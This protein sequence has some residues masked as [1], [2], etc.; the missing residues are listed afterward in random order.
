MLLPTE[1][2]RIRYYINILY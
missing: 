2:D 1:I